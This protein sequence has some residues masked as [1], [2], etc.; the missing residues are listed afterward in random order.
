MMPQY[1]V[2]DTPSTTAH[3]FAFFHKA[4]VIVNQFSRYRGLGSL[5]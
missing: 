1:T 5:L 3:I 2:Y 4:I